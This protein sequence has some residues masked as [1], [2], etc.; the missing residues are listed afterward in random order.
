MF[1]RELPDSRLELLSRTTNFA[2][3]GGAKKFER[4]CRLLVTPARTQTNSAL[5]VFAF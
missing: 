1:P 4:E 2:A 3:A 5:R